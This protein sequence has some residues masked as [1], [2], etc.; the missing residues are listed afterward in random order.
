MHENF[1]LSEFF[2]PTHK[3]GRPF[4]LVGFAIALLGFVFLGDIVGLAGLIFTAFCLYFFRDPARRV[5]TDPVPIVSPADGR[6]CDIVMAPWPA[7]LGGDGNDQRIR[8]S[9]FLSVLDVHVNRAPCAGRIKQIAYVPGKMLNA[10][11]EKASAD[12][13]RNIIALERSDGKTMAFVQI[14]GFVARR[15]VCDVEEG[16]ML[17]AGT[18]FGIIRFGSRMDVYLPE[19]YAPAIGMGQVTLGGETVIAMPAEKPEPKAIAV[20]K[21]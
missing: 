6:V 11:L 21:R 13:E 17:E 19:G 16:D 18:R 14:S 8:I 12:N 3:E 5:P 2:P 9:I 20:A 15:I 4:V 1:E 10:N 7:E